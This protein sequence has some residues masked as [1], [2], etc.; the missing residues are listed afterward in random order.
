M[1]VVFIPNLVHQLLDTSGISLYVRSKGG[2]NLVGTF[3]GGSGMMLL[4]HAPH[5]LGVVNHRAGAQR[6]IPEGLAF[7]YAHEEGQSRRLCQAALV[8]VVSGE[9]TEDARL[10]IA[11]V[12]YMEIQPSA[13]NAT[14]GERAITP[15]VNGQYRFS[16]EPGMSAFALIAGYGLPQSPLEPG[17]DSSEWKAMPRRPGPA[18]SPITG[19]KSVT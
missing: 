19:V 1:V 13:G 12:V 3:V 2:E 17:S 6:V 18:C 9:A 7:F 16:C 14:A 8:D 10:N 5:L 11:T 4:Y 15:E